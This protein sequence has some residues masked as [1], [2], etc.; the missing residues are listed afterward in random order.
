MSPIYEYRCPKDGTHME[1]RKEFHDDT[2][3]DCPICKQ[4]LRKVFTPVPTHFKS[5]GFYKTG[6]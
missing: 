2:D 3:P 4:P 6:G 5:S 1:I